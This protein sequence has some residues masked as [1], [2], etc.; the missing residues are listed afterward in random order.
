M[1]DIDG[2]LVL[3]N[4]AHALAWVEAFAHHGY[5]VEFSD[6]LPLIGMGGDKLIPKVA[7]GLDKLTDPGKKISSFRSELFLRKYA[8]EL[9]PAPGSR[10]LVQHLK[11]QGLKL[12]IASSA[13]EDELE[14]LLK[15]A[16]VD[17]LLDEAT[18]ASDAD[19]S[20]PDPDIVGAALDKIGLSAPEVL[21]LGDTPYDIKAAQECGIGVIAVRCGGWRD[22]D[23]AGAV[24]I[25]NDPADI[26]ANYDTSPFKQ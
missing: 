24:A 10:E 12:I 3:S 20:K 1:L 25:Y 26:L 18:T 17:D 2:T 14:T 9:K 11:S 16:G 4:E 7:P 5:T 15:A 13:S 21:M 23:L 8:P 22:A 6:V 19:D